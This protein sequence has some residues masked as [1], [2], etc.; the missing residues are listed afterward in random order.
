MLSPQHYKEYDT[1]TE[2]LAIVIIRQWSDE[3]EPFEDI[4]QTFKFHYGNLEE[5]LK[6]SLSRIYDYILSNQSKF[7]LSRDF[8]F[9]V[10]RYGATNSIISG[11]LNFDS[12]LYHKGVK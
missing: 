10:S 2:P 5:L 4:K 11:S 6:D 3:N 8:Y 12:D 7:D 1:I 9:K